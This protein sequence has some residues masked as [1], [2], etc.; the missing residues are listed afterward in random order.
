MD[1]GGLTLLE[2]HKVIEESQS[3]AGV[4]RETGSVFKRNLGRNLGEGR[5]RGH[6]VCGPRSCNKQRGEGKERR[7]DVQHPGLDARDDDTTR[8]E[9]KPKPGA[10][11]M[12][13]S[14]TARPLTPDPTF[15][16][17]ATPSFPA[18][19]GRRG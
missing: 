1:V 17:T 10:A 13:R 6:G 15:S 7:E 5:G 18:T 3:G 11:G 9:G 14:P 8:E 2:G 19:A 4:D 16:T 12:T